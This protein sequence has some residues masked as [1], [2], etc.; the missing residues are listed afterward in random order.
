MQLENTL[1]SYIVSYQ[2]SKIQSCTK[3]RIFPS[4]VMA[5]MAACA[6]TLYYLHKFNIMSIILHQLGGKVQIENYFIFVFLM[7][8]FVEIVLIF[9]LLLFN[10]TFSRYILICS[11]F[12]YNIHTNINLYTYAFFLLIYSH[13]L[14]HLH[15]SSC[16]HYFLRGVVAWHIFVLQD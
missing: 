13:W 15:L 8:W 2:M 14:D 16:N 3:A 9:L 7:L 10:Q 1:V 6:Q 11:S 4:S 5:K 12:I